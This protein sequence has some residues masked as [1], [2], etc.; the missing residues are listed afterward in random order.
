MFRVFAHLDTRVFFFPQFL[1][2]F[3]SKKFGRYLINKLQVTA[4]DLKGTQWEKRINESGDLFYPWMQAKMDFWKENYGKP[5]EAEKPP[6]PA[7]S[8]P[9]KKLQ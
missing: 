4:A 7:D 6:R 9:V 1:M 3:F 2:G 5:I 8:K